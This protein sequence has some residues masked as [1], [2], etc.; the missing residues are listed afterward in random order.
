[1]LSRRSSSACPVM[2]WQVASPGKYVLKAP[3]MIRRMG[4][5]GWKRLSRLAGDRLQGVVEPFPDVPAHLEDTVGSGAVGKGIDG[6]GPADVRRPEVGPLRVE[7]VAPGVSVAIAARELFGP[8]PC[9]LPLRGRRQP[10]ADPAGIS[11]GLI[12][13]DADHGM[14]RLPGRE[15]AALPVERTGPARPIGEPRYARPDLRRPDLQ[16]VVSA[17]LDKPLEVPVADRVTVEEEGTD[18]DVGIAPVT[19]G[20]RDNPGRNQRHPPMDEVPGWPGVT[21]TD[22]IG[23]FLQQDEDIAVLGD[24]SLRQAMDLIAGLVRV[25]TV[26]TAG[27]RLDRTPREGLRRGL[28]RRPDVRSGG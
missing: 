11:H 5:Q 2:N 1:M 9:L 22:L 28:G 24:Q 16:R 19:K 17:G 12:P 20:D 18:L 10:L 8:A 13:A 14:I 27:G 6:H 15:L 3:P 4:L 7:Q 23:G 21:V 25:G 26:A